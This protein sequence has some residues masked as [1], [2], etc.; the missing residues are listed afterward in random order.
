MEL[1]I[2]LND[3]TSIPVT[4]DNYSAAQMAASMNDR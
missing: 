4:M 2:F 3:N 1:T